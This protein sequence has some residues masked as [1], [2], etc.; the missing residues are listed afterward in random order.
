MASSIAG[1][2]KAWTLRSI[3]WVKLCCQVRFHNGTVRLYASMSTNSGFA[4][5]MLFI[6]SREGPFSRVASAPPG[7]DVLSTFMMASNNAGVGAWRYM[8]VTRAIAERKHAVLIRLSEKFLEELHLDTYSHAN[9]LLLICLSGM[10]LL[11][12]GPGDHLPCAFS[13]HTIWGNFPD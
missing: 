12:C 11:I 3:I 9:K 8:R 5:L 13:K 6:T 10:V 2:Q 7:A 1:P 4:L